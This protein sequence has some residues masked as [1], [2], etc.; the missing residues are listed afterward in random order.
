MKNKIIAML[1][2]V[3]LTFGTSA[4]TSTAV[5][6]AENTYPTTYNEYQEMLEEYPDFYRIDE[7]S[8]YFLNHNIHSMEMSLIVS[9]NEDSGVSKDTYG[10]V[11]TPES[12]GRYVVTVSEFCEEIVSE[13]DEPT[14]PGR[15]LPVE[16]PDH[17][18]NFYP[19]IFNY[20]IDVDNSGIS[21]AYKGTCNFKDWSE[22]T[23]DLYRPWETESYNSFVNGQIPDGELPV[24]D[25]YITN[26]YTPYTTESYFYSS[27]YG[28]YENM[29]HPVS[30]D[31]SVA[32]ETRT[33]NVSS[34]LDGN[35]EIGTDDIYEMTEF[36]A[37]SDGYVSITQSTN[38]SN[39]LY[40]E[41]TFNLMVKDGI[42]H[43]VPDPAYTETIYSVGI[44]KAPD[45]TI[46]KMGEDLEL[47]GLRLNG[48]I[49]TIVNGSKEISSI[50]NE[51]YTELVKSGLPLSIDDSGFDNSKA[52]T[53][54]IYVKLGDS[55]SFFNVTVTDKKLI[56]GDVNDDGKF[57]ISDVVTFQKWLI[58]DS[59]T[60]I[61][62]WQAA[63]V[64]KDGELNVF[65]LCAMKRKLI[66]QAQ[67]DDTPVLMI[68]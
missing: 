15:V 68:V 67:Y 30:S 36:A 63:D 17:Y 1:C 54:K 24:H 18:H 19:V 49:T 3:A 12:H 27:G 9:S 53:Y 4:I 32:K 29:P 20:T 22:P 61:T 44:E 65:D 35:F 58:K 37:G 5:T 52:G 40:Q 10:Y 14:E 64:C 13:P 60:N 8:V 25:S 46:Y 59:D 56:D 45:K 39:T 47:K 23:I 33:F 51:D 11:F 48:T 62:N 43:H 34:Y 6:A 31:T 66:N 16:L 41:Y 55:K 57:G 7:D 2:T 42:F 38:T 26:I 21:V 28:Y 50:M